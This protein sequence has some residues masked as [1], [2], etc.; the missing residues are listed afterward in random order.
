M[1]RVTV[2]MIE[3]RLPMHTSAIINECIIG[4]GSNIDPEINIQAALAILHQ[5][6]DVRGISKWVKT[7]PIGISNQSDFI[8]GAIKIHTVMSQESFR[9]YLKNLEDKLG[10]D[11]SL[12]RYGPRVIDLDIIVWNDDIIDDDYY[13]R[14]FVRNAINELKSP[15]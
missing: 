13:T 1:Q 5:E 3:N 12:P 2:F 4:V 10:R 7:A 15:Y 8:N 6:T 14:D 11:R 9:H